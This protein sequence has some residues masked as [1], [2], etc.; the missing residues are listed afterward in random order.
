MSDDVLAEISGSYLSPVPA[1]LRGYRRL[2]VKGEHYPALVLDEKGCVEGV[3]Y[4]NVPR[5]A[6]ARLDR[7]EGEMYL[8]EIVQVELNDGS[9]V[10]AE[11][12]VARDE[13]ADCLVDAEWNFADFLHKNKESFRRSYKAYQALK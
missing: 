2:C 8:R 5:A 9:L 12:Y 10:H 1:T 13:F 3:V 6:W 4:T 11:T 7:F